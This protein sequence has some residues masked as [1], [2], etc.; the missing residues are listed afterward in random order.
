MCEKTKSLYTRCVRLNPNLFGGLSKNISTK[1]QSK[2]NIEYFDW[3]DQLNLARQW[4]FDYGS[5]TPLPT[6][7]CPKM[8]S[9]KQS[10]RSFSRPNPTNP[11]G[12]G[13]WRGGMT[14]R[15]LH[16]DILILIPMWK[17]YVFW[18]SL[19]TDRQMD[20]QMEK[21]STARGLEELFS[22]VLE[23]FLEPIHALCVYC[24]KHL[25]HL[26][27]RNFSPLS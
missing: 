1:N 16:V 21:T 23:W 22:A 6:K 12:I 24:K 17:I 25:L 4:Q 18:Y 7:I 27:W 19:Q 9:T 8:H 26:G 5:S 14:D 2:K 3:A 10:R 15:C 20:R 11:V 13:I